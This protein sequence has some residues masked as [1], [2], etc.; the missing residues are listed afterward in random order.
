MPEFLI[1]ENLQEDLKGELKVT[2]EP[3]GIEVLDTALEDL[4]GE[5]KV[6]TIQCPF[7]LTSIC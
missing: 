7:T 5:L 1:V 2:R 4:K 6:D 3:F